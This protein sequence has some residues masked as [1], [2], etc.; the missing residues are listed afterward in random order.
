MATIAVNPDQVA[1]VAIDEPIRPAVAGAA[2]NKGQNVGFDGTSGR[3]TL[4]GAR[5]IA[6]SKAVAARY[7]VSTLKK[8]IVEL[9]DALQTLAFGAAVYG[10]PN[11][12]LDDVA[13]GNIRVGT[14]IEGWS[15][16]PPRKL[17]R[18]EL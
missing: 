13:T 8:G 6:V 7:E 16:S 2:I 11:G 17:L 18:V 15:Q 14:V 3:A 12:S 4:G 10:A 1:I 5:A 9:G